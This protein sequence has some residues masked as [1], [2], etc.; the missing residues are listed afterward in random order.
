[1]DIQRNVEY[2]RQDFCNYFRLD[3]YIME[4]YSEQKI[5]IEKYIEETFIP[6]VNEII[7]QVINLNNITLCMKSC[8]NY[9]KKGT[10]PEI[11]VVNDTFMEDYIYRFISLRKK[12]EEY[13]EIYNKFDKK[14]YEPMIL[15]I[16][17][18]EYDVRR[19]RIEMFSRTPGYTFHCRIGVKKK[20]QHL[21]NILSW[22]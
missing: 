22:C 8:V 7:D 4:Q 13:I 10:V 2:I 5:E 19:N 11:H 15:N 20:F 16:F 14:Y 3:K 18:I 9:S 12:I 1:M 21:K 6:S 17:G